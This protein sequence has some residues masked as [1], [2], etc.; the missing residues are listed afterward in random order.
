MAPAGSNSADDGEQEVPPRR[1]SRSGS[2]FFNTVHAAWTGE[3]SRVDGPNFF[4]HG[5]EYVV[6]ARP[7]CWKSLRLIF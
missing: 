3:E 5:Q 6:R 1:E 4:V 7:T 2:I